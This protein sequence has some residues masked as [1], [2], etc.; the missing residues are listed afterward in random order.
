[1]QWK[2][3]CCVAIGILAAATGLRAE[4]YPFDSDAWQIEAEEAAVVD[5]LGERAL[6]LQ[7]G[8]ATLDGI[9]MTDGVIEFDI[10]AARFCGRFLPQCRCAQP[11]TLLHPPASV[12][13]SGRESVQP[14][15][16]RARQLAALSWRRLWGAS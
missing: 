14:R 16:Q 9:E 13:Q 15:L 3:K 11:G 1:M 8:S 5:Y 2:T 7:G 6:L 4:Q 10:A 12:G